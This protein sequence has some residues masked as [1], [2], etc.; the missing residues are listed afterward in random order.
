M[1]TGE[2]QEN[3]QNEMAQLE[4]RFQPDFA[5]FVKKVLELTGLKNLDGNEREDGYSIDYA[6]EYMSG[7]FTPEQYAERV[8]KVLPLLKFTNILSTTKTGEYDSF[9][10]VMI[11]E[12]DL[13]ARGLKKW[14]EHRFGEIEELTPSAYDCTGRTWETGRSFQKIGHCLYVVSRHWAV[15]C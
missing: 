1:L 13:D 15:D 10:E 6:Y 8:K 2:H 4:D 12:T 14:A 5:A 3:W 11:V 9:S 7:G